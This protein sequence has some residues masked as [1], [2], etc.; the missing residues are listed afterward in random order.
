LFQ[1]G[2]WRVVDATGFGIALNLSAL[3]RAF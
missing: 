3:H 2:F 1:L